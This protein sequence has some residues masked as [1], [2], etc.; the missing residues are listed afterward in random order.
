MVAIEQ[1]RF[2]TGIAAHGKA[3]SILLPAVLLLS[4][5]LPVFFFIAGL[6]LSP[7][8]LI[9]LLSVVP[10]VAMA[11]SG[12]AGGMKWPDTLVLVHC[13]WAFLAMLVVHGLDEVPYA[14]MYVI[15]TAGAYFLGRVMIRNIDQFRRLMS[16]FFCIVLILIPFA[17][18]ESFTG[19]LLLNDLF[20]PVMPVLPRLWI[21]GRWGLERAQGPLEHPILYGVFVGAGFGLFL[22]SV[23][24][25]PGG[26]VGFMRSMAAVVAVFPSLSAGPFT[27]LVFQI[28]LALWDQ[29]MKFL[30]KKWKILGWIAI[31]FYLTIDFLS[32]RTPF[33]IFI[34]YLTFNSGAAYNRVLI[35][36]FGTQNVASHPFFGLGLNDWERPR[37]M[38]PSV[39]N[40]W[41]LA[42]M[43]YGLP[44]AVTMIALTVGVLL[45][46]GRAQMVSAEAISVRKGYL[47]SMGGMILAMCTV[48][49]WNA[50]YVFYMFMLGV[51]MCMADG[52]QDTTDAN[53]TASTVP[54][55]GRPRAVLGSME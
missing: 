19:R 26:P 23:G 18:Y 43:R 9:L 11:I 47:M 35:W 2:E 21:E 31:F 33:H 6:R 3:D 51:G 8:R 39:D 27:G 36:H 54:S 50:T 48:H 5:I 12:R 16:V 37:W 13:G 41:L 55:T 25:R 42:A 1:R 34:D 40:F 4:L 15:E 45:K 52:E 20:R 22:F 14:G 44:A 10:M 30:K 29:I 28:Q 7:Y 17:Y 53:D 38:G 32:N 49:L 24:R 46:V